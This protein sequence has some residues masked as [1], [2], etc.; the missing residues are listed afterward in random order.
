MKRLMFELMLVAVAIAAVW[1]LLKWRSAYNE[2]AQRHEDN[3]RALTAEVELARYNDSL[4]MANVRALRLKS[5]EVKELTGRDKVYK[6]MGV[7]KARDVKTDVQ[8]E[9]I[10]RDTVCFDL[11]ECV[12]LDTPLDTCVN[13]HDNWCDVSLCLCGDTASVTYSV[14]DSIS[15]IVHVSY[16][17]RFLWW[18]WKPEYRAT[19]V[20]HNPRATIISASALVVED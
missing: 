5:S 7:Q 14:R 18:R 15:T 16:R 2:L 13:H 11:S 12:P 4:S 1:L 17:K 19:T 6:E 8:M 20:N 9:S 10:I 3:V